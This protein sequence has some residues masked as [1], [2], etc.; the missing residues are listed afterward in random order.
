MSN[1]QKIDSLNRKIVSLSAYV[2]SKNIFLERISQKMEE[3]ISSN[4]RNNLDL[5]KVLVS[6]IRSHIESQSEFDNMKFHF[7]EVHPRFYKKLSSINSDLTHKD[8]RLCAF[9]KMQFTNKE[10]AFLLNISHDGIKKA[11]QRLRKKLKVKEKDN[12]RT[13]IFSLN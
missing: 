11:I 9:L 1:Q 3:V 10:I 5:L 13:L 8:L 7:E 4:N 2:D 6:E 12:L